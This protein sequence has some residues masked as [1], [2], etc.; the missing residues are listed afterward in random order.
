M[1]GYRQ[2]L[3]PIAYQVNG[4][5]MAAVS[6]PVIRKVSPPPVSTNP[7]AP[8]RRGESPALKETFWRPRQKSA[9]TVQV[10]HPMLF[11][12]L[13]GVDQLYD[14]PNKKQLILLVGLAC[15]KESLSHSTQ[16]SLGWG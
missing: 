10:W 4:E 2:I 6:C 14:F 1:P 3:E 7:E 5:S 13:L 8:P 16:H 15:P 9:V 12:V 11:W